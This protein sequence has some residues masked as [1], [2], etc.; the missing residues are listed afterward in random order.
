MDCDIIFTWT[1][2]STNITEVLINEYDGKQ[3]WISINNSSIRVKNA[4]LYRSIRIVVR[5][6]KEKFRKEPFNDTTYK[7]NGML[8]PV[9]CSYLK[10]L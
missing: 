9:T 7:Y 1:G 5:V 3:D 6:Y 8:R 4:L 2:A 10:H